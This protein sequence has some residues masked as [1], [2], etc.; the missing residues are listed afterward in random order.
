MLPR[1]NDIQQLRVASRETRRTLSLKQIMN[2]KNLFYLFLIATTLLSTIPA[3]AQNCNVALDVHIANDVSS[4][5]N[6]REHQQS[7]NFI[8]ALGLHLSPLGTGIDSSRISIS[9]WSYRN[10]FEEYSFPSAG[11]TFTTLQSDLIAYSNSARPFDGGTAPYTAL[12]KAYQWVLQDPI[13]GTRGGQPVII[14]MTDA[15]C[16]QIPGNISSLATQIKN[17]GITIVVMAIDSA[18]SCSALEDEKV[19]SPGA[20]FAAADYA[21]LQDQALTYINYI[22]DVACVPVDLYID[23]S[24]E[25]SSFEI[26]NCI[27]SPAATLNYTITNSGTAEFNSGTLDIAFY[28]GKPTVPGTQHLFTDSVST[29]IAAYGGTYAGSTTNA[30]LANAGRVFAVVNIDGSLAANT[31]PL[32]PTLNGTTLTDATETSTGNNISTAFTRTDGAGCLP[33]AHIDVQV[34]HS[35]QVCDNKLIYYVEVC[36]IGTADFEMDAITP[37]ADASFVLEETLLVGA[38]PFVGSTLPAGACATYHY[39][40]DLD[41]ATPGITYDFSVDVKEVEVFQFSCGELFLDIRDG[42]SYPTVQIGT[43]CW[44]AENLNV[45]T[46]AVNVQYGNQTNDGTIE[47]WCYN[48]LEANCDDYGG[49]YQ[50]EEAMGYVTT[51]G[52]QGICPTGWHVPTLDETAILWEAAESNTGVDWDHPGAGR[53]GTDVGSNLK[54]TG[55]TYWLTDPGSTNSVG[56]SARG[57]GYRDAGTGFMYLKE[58]SY[59]WTSSSWAQ[60]GPPVTWP[61]FWLLDHDFTDIGWF[62]D[63]YPWHATSIRC[64]LD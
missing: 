3:T 22:T 29:S 61:Y 47:K 36:N 55:T 4:S 43:Q 7:K 46:F 35:G 12:R 31:V 50:W 52:A 5:V 16:S 25:I 56:F 2:M 21:T 11:A 6:S 53:M 45:G 8:T 40:Y 9:Q 20:Y 54:E 32:S 34:S 39:T 23:L 64:L 44:M 49:L 17:S 14:L 26:I 13:P 42:K 27:T 10:Y 24:P 58:R 37:Y 28:N 33:Y 1:L 41:L 57:G 38:D 15:Y 51:E 48:D 63:L 30:A 60:S 18:A 62:S 19:A 59:I